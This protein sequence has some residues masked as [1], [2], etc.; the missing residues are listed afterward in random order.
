[1]SRSDLVIASNRGPLQF[2]LH[3]DGTLSSGRGAGGLISALVPALDG[4]P[5]TW[6]AAAIG[7]GD[8]VAVGR[9][10]ADVS[11]SP[12]LATPGPGDAELRLLRFDQGL[13]ER[14]YHEVSNRVLWFLHHYLLDA[15]AV[16]FGREFRESWAC[17]RTVNQAFANAC[18]AVAGPGAEVHVEDYHLGLVPAL[19][20]ERRPDLR[21]AHQVCCPWTDPEWF[22][23][24]PD[25]VRGQLLN[26][27]LG[28]DLVA[29]L[30][31]RWAG[32]FLRCCEA[33][34][35]AVEQA[36]ATVR[37]ADGRRVRVRAFPLGVDEQLLRRLLAQSEPEHFASGHGGDQVGEE[38]RLIVRVDRMEPTKNI[39]R[40]LD[41]YASFLE[42]HPTQ[43]GKVCHLVI[44]NPSRSGMAEY[45]RYHAAVE[46]QVEEV[47]RRYGRAGWVP[48]R[49]LVLD[50]H[51]RALRALAAADVVVVNPLWDGMNLAAK[52]AACVN[53]RDAVLILSRN[54]GA[55]ADLG[56]G[57]LLVN[58]FDVAALADTLAA[59]LAMDP[60][61]RARRAALLRAAASRLPPRA[62]F[63]LQRDALRPPPHA[64]LPGEDRP[65]E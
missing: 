63:G 44:A 19:L 28:A 47:N 17:Y 8:S 15:S 37:A 31:A 39:L 52:E 49:L 56:D 50:D 40:G 53:D 20:R 42:A 41:G 22:G 11:G 60:A 13:Y 27:M 61:E 33:A 58:P 45:Q 24:L 7:A 59:A 12:P 3:P 35:F 25:E 23:I 55:A 65:P 30:T 34:G 21:I 51:P 18:S 32:S 38:P 2:T 10:M 16:A 5:C 9:A 54:A 57:A 36:T 4:Q 6:I 46:Q 1:M 64:A 62:W 48:A 14:Y 26:G 29:F 43:H